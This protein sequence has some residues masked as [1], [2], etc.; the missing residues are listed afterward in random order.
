VSV[1]EQNIKYWGKADYY[2]FLGSKLCGKMDK[3]RKSCLCI[4]S[5]EEASLSELL[6]LK[7]GN[8]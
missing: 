7:K 6:E 1:A 5:M 4:F 8:L 3:E 2:I